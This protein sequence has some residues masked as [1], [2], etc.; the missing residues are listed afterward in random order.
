MG[1]DVVV[2]D[3]DMPDINGAEFARALE[4]LFPDIPVIMVSGRG[5]ALEAARTVAAIKHVLLKPYNVA[6][7][8]RVIQ[9]VVGK[10]PAASA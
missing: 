5:T 9:E 7:L 10:C 3:Y 6:D 8:T 2:T 4:Q 1:Y